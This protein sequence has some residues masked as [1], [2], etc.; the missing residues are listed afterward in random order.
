M[1]HLILLPVYLRL[2]GLFYLPLK[3]PKQP[4]SRQHAHTRES[5][6]YNTRVDFFTWLLAVSGCW[7][8]PFKWAHLLVAQTAATHL[9]RIQNSIQL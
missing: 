6:L 5:N 2:Y 4:N 9:L 7:Y 3:F 1:D 8:I